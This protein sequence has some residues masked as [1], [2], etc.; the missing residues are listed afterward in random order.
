MLLLFDDFNYRGLPELFFNIPPE[1][2]LLFE[3]W[4]YY[5]SPEVILISAG[6]MSVVPMF[7]GP[8][9]ALLELFYST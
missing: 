1:G 9:A 6:L 7:D 8:R 2:I 4:Y 5:L 3:G